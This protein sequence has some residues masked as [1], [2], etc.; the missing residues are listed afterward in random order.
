MNQSETFIPVL[1]RSSLE[2]AQLWGRLTRL[3]P[4]EAELTS[5]FELAPGRTV[6]LSFELRGAFEDIRARVKTA[7]RDSDGYFSYSLIFLDPVQS[8]LLSAA[9]QR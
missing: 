8:S 7:L 3:S 1:I 6:T 9:I 5:Q 4:Q 2:P